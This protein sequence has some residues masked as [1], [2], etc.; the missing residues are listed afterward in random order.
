[1][2]RC[3]MV[4]MM[5]FNHKNKTSTDMT[6]MGPIKKFCEKK[7]V[8]SGLAPLIVEEIF[9]LSFCNKGGGV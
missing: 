5:N 4:K 9:K 8:T 7:N 2:I 1:M 3:E 6:V